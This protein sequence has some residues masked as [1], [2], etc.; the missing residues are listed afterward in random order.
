MNIGS[1]FPC[2]FEKNIKMTLTVFCSMAHQKN[3]RGS[4]LVSLE[5]LS[6]KKHG[7]HQVGKIAR[8]VHKTAC[9][10][11]KYYT[12]QHIHLFVKMFGCLIYCST[13]TYG[14]YRKNTNQKFTV[15]SQLQKHLTACIMNY[16]K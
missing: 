5:I 6:K 1:N 4:M 13:N 2:W 7:Y 10:S 14:V 16:S 11:F 3:Q 15:M 9:E 12:E 8:I